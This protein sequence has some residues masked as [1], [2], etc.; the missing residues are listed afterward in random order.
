MAKQELTDWAR[1]ARHWTCGACGTHFFSPPA[2][3]STTPIAC[4]CGAKR[5]KVRRPPSSTLAALEAAARDAAL[6]PPAGYRYK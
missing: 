1:G 3:G 6:K 4:S 2:A 5:W